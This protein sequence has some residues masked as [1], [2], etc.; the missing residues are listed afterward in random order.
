MRPY[1]S[2]KPRVGGS[3]PSG[4][5]NFLVGE[6]SSKRYEAR[7]FY[8]RDQALRDDLSCGLGI[9]WR[10]HRPFPSGTGRAAKA[11]LNEDA[12]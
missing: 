10:R 7:L 6:T 3:N 9:E 8:V 11:S 4:R 2:S 1:L 5:A 12:S